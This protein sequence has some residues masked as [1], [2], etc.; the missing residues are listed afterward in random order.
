MGQF[1]QAHCP[2]GAKPTRT[3]KSTMFAP[4]VAGFML[5]SFSMFAV[6]N[7]VGAALRSVVHI[8]WDLAIVGAL[9]MCAFADLLFPRV[10]LSLLKRQTP[11]SLPALLPLPIAGFLWGVDTGSV[12]STLRSSAASWAALI[13]TFGGWGSWW[14]GVVYGAAFCLPLVLLIATYPADGAPIGAAGWR[15]RSTEALAS[16]FMRRVQRIRLLAA[17]AAILG[18][19]ISLASLTSI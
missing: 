15:R 1:R 18:V 5:A 2:V 10:R 3:I 14:T 4:L 6:A 7:V 12:V 13:A 19:V 11:R 8:P 9:I 17:T 16:V